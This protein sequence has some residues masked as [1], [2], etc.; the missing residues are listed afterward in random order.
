MEERLQLWRPGGGVPRSGNGSDRAE[1][2]NGWDQAGPG[3]GGGGAGWARARSPATQVPLSP[4]GPRPPGSRRFAPKGGLGK[5]VSLSKP[6]AQPL[7][8]WAPPSC[9]QRGGARS[10]TGREGRRTPANR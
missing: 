10:V 3:P 5:G 2:G 4:P 6:Q 9:V 1:T 7:L 8:R